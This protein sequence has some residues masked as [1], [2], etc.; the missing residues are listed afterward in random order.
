MGDASRRNRID[1]AGMTKIA[2][3][4]ALLCATSYLVI[5]LP[6]T[7]IVLSLQTIMV[8]L[9]GFILKPRHAAYALVIYIALGLIGLPVFSGGTSGP[10]KLFGPTGGFYFGFLFAAIAI[11]LLK[12]KPPRLFR[13]ALISIGIGIPIEH[14][15]AILFMCFYNDF[16]IGAAALT[17]SIPFL[18]GDVIKCVIASVVGVG[19]GKVLRDQKTDIRR[20]AE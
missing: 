11:S 15:F 7:P 20:I 14:S 5:P 4:V 2:L 10:G 19:L 9:I 13:Y 16:R 18:L 12:G 6:F 3:C 8:N 17:V 1:T